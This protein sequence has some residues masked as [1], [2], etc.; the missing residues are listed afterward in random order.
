MIR[1]LLFLTIT[2]SRPKL[3]DYLPYSQ[4]FF[5]FFFWEKQYPETFDLYV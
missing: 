5:F 4:L 3:L 2:L 1:L